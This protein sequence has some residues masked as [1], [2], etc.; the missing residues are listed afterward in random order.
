MLPLA[1]RTRTLSGMTRWLLLVPVLSL[2]CGSSSSGGA[3][4]AG[5]DLCT[6]V[7]APCIA[8]PAGSPE[9]TAATAFVSAKA[10]TTIVFDAGT[11]AFTNQVDIAQANITVKGQGAAKTI[12]DFS[13]QLA[14]SEAVSIAMSDGFA[15]RDLAV[16][17]AK[18]D[19]IKIIGSKGV[20]FANV[21]VSW[22]RDPASSHGPYG[23]YPVQCQNVLIDGCDVSG[24]T[25]S[26]IY[27]GQSEHIVVRN[28]HAHD[29]VAGI[30]IENSHF[31]DVHDNV[32]ENNTGGILVFALPGLQVPDCS[33]VR[34]FSNKILNNN[35]TSFADPG[36]I[37]AQV[38]AGTGSFVLSADR[39]EVF[40]NTFD[41][42]ATVQM[43]IIS[44]KV[45]MNPIPAGYY[46]Y[47]TNISIHDNTWA[48]G[49]TKPDSKSLLGS[50]L[51]TNMSM[52]VPPHVPDILYDGYLDP[53]KN[54]GPNPQNPMN[55]CIGGLAGA[56][57][58]DLHAETL[59]VVKGFV[60][61]SQDVTPFSCSIPALAAVTLPGM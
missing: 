27:V 25:D 41:G 24:A 1:R 37:V 15:M 21:N 39:V 46:P 34:V 18:G 2:G 23:I 61:L 20:T 32:A 59:D 9:K 35:T 16:R 58:A 51:G 13:G 52:F 50:L 38:P 44:Y 28:N 3:A 4:A 43:A 19:A 31:A 5:P 60:D 6:G 11:F 48:N 53:A 30:E 42:N 45:T 47:P 7:P 26:G 12:F 33:D 36:D 49:G 22:T 8:V 17:D 55:V 29:N 10:G 54:I 14:G 56:T 57:F 40:G